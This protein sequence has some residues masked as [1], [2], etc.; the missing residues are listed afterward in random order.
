MRLAG[1]SQADTRVLVGDDDVDEV[2]RITGGNPLFLTQVGAGRPTRD[3]LLGATDRRLAA[4]AAE[5]AEVVLAVAVLGPYASLPRLAAV[6]DRAETA[7]RADVRRAY[8]V[9][10]LVGD[11]PVR[12]AHPL[13]AEAA[14]A[15]APARAAD[16]HAAAARLLDA[17]RDASAVA[18]HL[19]EAGEGH[20]TEAVEVLLRAAEVASAD[21]AH[22]LAVEHLRQA[23]AL[24]DADTEP[25]LAWRVVFEYA[26]AVRSAEGR[27]AAE[28]HYLR[29]EE[30]AVA[31]GDQEVVA[32]S[33]AR[34]GIE[35]YTTGEHVRTRAD[36]CREALAALPAG[37]SPLRVTLLAQAAVGGMAGLDVAESRRTADEAV[38]MAR[39][40]ADDRALGLALVAQQVVD[41]GPASMPRRLTTAREV[42]DLVDG[43]GDVPLAIHARFLLKAALLEAGEV[44]EL[45][46]HVNEQQRDV[47]RLSEAR[48]ERHH[49]WFRCMQAMLD[50]DADRVEDLAGQIG[51][52]SDRL[53]DPDGVGVYFGQLG[54]ARWL[55]GR[56]VEMEEAYLSQLRDEPDEPLW[57]AVLGWVALHEG[58]LDVVRGWSARFA[59][60]ADV[61]EGM[62]TLLT[63][64][65][66]ADVWAAVGTDAQ[67][68]E[69]WE[70]LVPYADRVVPLALGAG[71]FGPVARFL[72]TL[73]VRR[74]QRVEAVA[75]FEQAIEVAGRMGARPWVAD[76]QVA[77]AE[78]LVD[79]SVAD[80][81][82]AA[83]LVRQAAAV[84]RTGVVVLDDRLAALERRLTHAPTDRSVRI[85]L[86]GTFEVRGLDGEVAC[87]TSRKART[88]LKLLAAAGGG[89][90][91]RD[92]LLGELWPG[93]DPE[94]LG[95]RLAVALT[96]VRRALDPQRTLTSPLVAVSDDGVR[97][98]T[99]HP[100]VEVRVDAH[101]FL[102]EARA[103]RV[104]GT[105][106]A[107]VESAVATF[108]GLP[109]SEEPYAGWAVPLRQEVS[110]VAVGLL[111]RAVT[112]A[113]A[114]G[115]HVAVAERAAQV[116]ELEP[117]DESAHAARVR[118][119][120]AMGAHAQADRAA[121]EF[122]TARADLGL[123]P[124]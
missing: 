26:G 104:R 87:W 9:D 1:L 114:D 98:V 14:V 65:T 29:A 89:F 90:V 57:P 70:A 52:I 47:A 106:R 23:D 62:H 30:F 113:E 88:L 110:V 93:T 28:P 122:R 64:A 78:L 33:V 123:A 99:D 84:R 102:A 76:A 50:G 13:F 25:G 120:R 63:L 74:G 48:W 36:R 35:Y 32:R 71:L 118:A 103:A 117:Y 66:T 73:A 58:H 39:R 37:D 124:S 34:H 112:L 82:R 6:L 86:L 85:D 75:R 61:P 94:A 7:V 69:V 68:D 101:A 111:G 92:R 109:F 19:A 41:L 45:D 54:V 121:E 15:A 108:G 116:L 42:L 83:D 27:V 53:Q 10:V 12:T 115:D 21:F 79:G 20:R 51:V 80:R 16:L 44:R 4:L 11:D 43:L 38:A 22:E 49:L 24:L 31:T 18:R 17:D 96:T 77:L 119:L 100:Q 8:E 60:P 55:Q 56:L 67:V 91:P 105:S 3:T 72:G 2:H 97:L 46:A 81:T 5:V 107:R 59:R 95:N 40:C